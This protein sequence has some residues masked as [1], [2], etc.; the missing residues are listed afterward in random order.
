MPF[1]NKW[2]GGEQVRCAWDCF[3]AAWDCFAFAAAWVCCAFAA[4]WVC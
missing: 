2:I 3:A 1:I 4:A